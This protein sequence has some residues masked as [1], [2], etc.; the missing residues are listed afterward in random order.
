MLQESPMDACGDAA[1][2]DALSPQSAAWLAGLR[3]HGEA[4]GPVQP[5]R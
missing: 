2:R 1:H 4:A 3:E 5:R